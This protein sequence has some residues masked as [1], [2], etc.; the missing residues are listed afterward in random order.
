MYFQDEAGVDDNEAPIRGRSPKGERC[1]AMKSGFAK[2][3]LS[4]IAAHTASHMPN[5]GFIAPFLIEGTVRRVD[6]EFWLES[7]FLPKIR[8]GSY[9]FTDN[10]SFHKNGNIQALFDKFGCY[11]LYLPT[12]SPDLNSIE[13]KWPIV[14]NK[15]RKVLTRGASLFNALCDI[16]SDMTCPPISLLSQAGTSA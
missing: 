7:H 4:I 3:R 15:T 5:Q 2:K 10:A 16:L 1:H 13:R 12:Y 9:M 11:L 6:F 14:K 8:P